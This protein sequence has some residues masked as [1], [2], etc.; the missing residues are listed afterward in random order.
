MKSFSNIGKQLVNAGVDGAT[1]YGAKKAFQ[2]VSTQV[3][4]IV[5][6]TI[7]PAMTT[8]GVGA[9]VAI[10]A[11]MVLPPKFGRLAGAVAMEQVI[12]K[13]VDP[14]VDPT[15]V[16]SGLIA[17]SDLTVSTAAALAAPGATQGYAMRTGSYAGQ[18]GMAGYASARGMAG[19]AST[20]MAGY[21][22]GMGNQAQI[23]P[24]TNAVGLPG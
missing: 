9:I 8:L 4:K 23:F 19:Y 5:P 22:R 11:D 14:V 20:P 7:N 15:L 18:A 12:E 17:A 16:T 6:V 24:T 13:F 21:A 10:L 2:V 3:K 1:L